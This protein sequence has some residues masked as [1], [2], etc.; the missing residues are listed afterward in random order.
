LLYPQQNE[1][2]NVLDISGLWGFELDPGDVGE[3]QA[4]YKKLPTP[5]Q[6]AVPA[7]WNDQFQDTRDYLGAAWYARDFHVPSGWEGQRIHVRIGS[8]V[9]AA[10]VWLNGTLV[11]R[12]EGPHLP[13]S[14]DVTDQIVW[15]RPNH[16][17]I[18]VENELRPNRVPPGNVASAIGSFMSG[19]PNTNY[20]FFPYAGLHR[21]VILY[22][23]P[24][25]RIDDI[26][27]TTD[28]DGTDGLVTVRVKQTADTGLG[29]VALIGEDTK[30]EADLSFASGTAEGTLRVP[31]AR[32][33][34]P[35]DPYLY[36]LS[37]T[38]S[39]GGA[40]IDRYTLEIGIRTIL[41]DGDQLLLNGQPIFLKG[42]GRHEDS[43]IHGRGLNLPM[44]IKDN[45]LLKW[46]G[47]NSYRTSHYPY[48]EEAMLVAD[49]EGILVIDETPCVGLFF[50]D[51]EANIQIRLDQSQQ[52]LRDLVAR[53]K[54]HPSVIMWSVANEPVPLAM[55]RRFTGIGDTE[56][57]DSAG[58]A[59]L[60]SLIDLAHELD[61]TRPATLAGMMASPV[62]WLDLCD[63][64]CINRYWG[65]YTQ[66]GQLDL[67][68]Q[69]LAQEL[70]SLH[71]TLRKPIVITEFGTD[72]IAGMHSDPPEMWTEEYQVEFLRRYLDVAAERPFVAGLHVWNMADFKTGQ[73]SRRAGGMNLKGVFTRDRRP[74]MAAHLLRQRWN[75]SAKVTPFSTKRSSPQ[76]A[77]ATVHE[78]LQSLA[79]RLKPH[80]SREVVIAFDIEGECVY[81]LVI[82]QGQATLEV[83]EGDADLFLTMGSREAIELATGA[84]HPMIA[85]AT[86]R[87]RLEGKPEALS[88]LGDIF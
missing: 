70:D 82:G 59:F 73:S 37:V 81:R 75:P 2:R 7:S 15:G 10:Q 22:S 40:I 19:N 23:V 88:A 56:D 74:K 4:W 66:A 1:V 47:A 68:A 83:G 26:T 78:A 72:T 33:W 50:E 41:V 80:P 17:A 67:G 18:R 29:H 24:K 79:Q 25:T 76:T 12:H 77:P 53:D 49:R 20:D 84:L 54:N 3:Q 38:L 86:N 46:V 11:G 31:S 63:V 48:S 34:C 36:A 6:I 43:A 42:F 62:E 64:A 71:E 58:T 44:V 45:S 87:I 35:E 39:E 65:W 16:L 85:I 9:Y 57:N 28:I 55:V 52:Y 60:E 51:G 14:L 61:P 8:A 27:V 5:R 32:F 13:F 69:M 30:V 21:P